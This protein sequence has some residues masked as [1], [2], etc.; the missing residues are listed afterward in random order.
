MEE[1]SWLDHYLAFLFDGSLPMDEK[2]AE[3]VDL[4]LCQRHAP[5]LYQPRGNLNPIISPW[6]FA[7]WGLDIIRPF[8]CALEN[9]RYVVVATDYFNKWVEAEA[10]AN[11]RDVDV[12]KFVWKNIITR[13]SSP[14]YPQSNEQAEVTNKTIVNDLKQRLEG[15]K[16]NWVEKLLNVLWAYQTTSRRSMGETPFSMTYG[17]EAVIPIK[18]GLSS[19]RVTNFT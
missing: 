19:M 15:V 3:N 7:Q 17:T 10:L 18:V 12:K 2:E 14:M 13:Y 5:I 9:K 16:G 4:F 11:I 6:P 8:P 1:P